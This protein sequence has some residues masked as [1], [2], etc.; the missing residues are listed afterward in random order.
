[1]KIRDRLLLAAE[2]QFAEVG[3]LE[4]TLAQIRE[5]AGASVGALYHHFPDKADLYRQVWAHA[6]EDYQQHFWVAVS[7]S[8][9]AREGVTGGVREHLRWVTENQYRAKVLMSARPPGVRE[10]ET[11]RRFLT[12][13]S[14]WWRTHANYGAVRDLSL[15]LVYA[16]WLGPAQEYSRQ[17]VD[18]A[19]RA[20]PI[21]V[22]SELAD[23]AWLTLG[24]EG[25]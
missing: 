23:A 6:L 20:A 4:T 7:A 14:R 9:D 15:D 22:G 16:L 1:M 21:E 3:A 8:S 5:A 24:T 10:S 13:I 18:G 17:W 19:V 2:R 25:R 12:D 11:N